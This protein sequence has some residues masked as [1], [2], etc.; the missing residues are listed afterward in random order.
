MLLAG[1]YVYFSRTASCN[2]VTIGLPVLNRTN[3]AYKRTAG[4]F[5]NQSPV[6]FAFGRE[7][8]FAELL[9]K[10]GATLKTV[11]R[12]QRFPAS[13]IRRAAGA[14]SNRVRLFD[15]G[16]S[17]ESHDY[18]ASFAGIDGRITPLL[19][20]WEQAPLQVFVRDFYAG[21]DVRIDFVY[22]QA[23]FTAEDIRSLHDRFRIVLEAAVANPQG[24][25]ASWPLL[26]EAERFQLLEAWNAT[27]VP[28]PKDQCVHELFEIQADSSPEA[29][30]VAFGEQC[31]TY[32]E[33]NASANRLA[34]HLITQG[35]RPD[36]RVAIGVERSL[37]MVVGL[38]AIL[39]AGG[40][41]VPLDPAYP[42]ER[43]AFMLEDSTP[44]A[45]LVHGAT[46]ERFATLAQGL[47]VVDLDAD[48]G[49]WAERS[50]TNPNPTAFGLTSNHLAYVIYTSGSTGKPKGVMIEHRGVCNLVTAQIRE[51]ALGPNS[52][53]LQFASVS[54]DACVMEV[55]N[56]LC[57]G[58]VLHL[59]SPKIKLVGEALA[60]TI[61]R[62][63]ISHALLPP[64]V[65]ATQID[66]SCFTTLGTLISGGERLPASLSRYWATNRRLI[67]AYGP[68][69]ATVC[70]TMQVCEARKDGNPPIG[71]P[72][73][74]SRI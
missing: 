71:R 4:L 38:L 42:E 3:A 45:L 74:N 26:S 55:F 34:H 25:V 12:H 41:Y 57:S 46:R 44:V 11:Y 2:E 50:A 10:I 30:A 16:L 72:I 22:N 7:L 1:L 20:S 68:T 31:L 15:V 51:F 49:A 59:P 40:A 32:A 6:R 24:T 53:F 19:H 61:A 23:Y 64:S 18:Q 5:A 67:N 21:S 33:L 69:E 8:C 48:A 29:I 43:L 17:F 52:R 54:F 27:E 37:E 14:E 13:E 47:P 39:K 65:L 35:I 56:A 70:A 36:D 58:A 9:E 73:A 28:Y 60:S 62:H 66:T 63:G